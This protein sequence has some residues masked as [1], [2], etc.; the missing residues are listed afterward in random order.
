MEQMRQHLQRLALP[1]AVL[2]LFDGDDVHPALSYRARQPEHGMG[3]DSGLSPDFIPFWECGIVVSGFH[4]GQ[5]LFQRVSLEDPEAPYAAFG[6][7]SHLFAD[8]IVDLWEDET[9][10]ND[11]RD[12]AALF[13]MPALD[14]LLAALETGPHGDY[15]NWRQTLV[16][17]YPAL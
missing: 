10:T 13:G 6:Q 12:I 2:G 15:C 3:P 4:A 7:F 17:R 9:L 11:L 16:S 14:Q 1:Q 8:L 5:R